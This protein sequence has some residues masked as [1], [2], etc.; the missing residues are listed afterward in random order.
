MNRKLARELCMKVIFEMLMNKT[1]DKKL[2]KN[3]LSEEDEIEEIQ[4]TYIQTVITS[5]IEHLEEINRVIEKYAI[6]WTLDRIAK[7][8]LAILQ[9]AL[10]EILYIEDIP[11]NVS[12]NE[13]VELAKKYSSNE[14]TSFINGILG[15]FIEKEGIKK[16][17]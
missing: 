17:D 9:L 8:D 15:K 2:L 16:N 5:T 10:A 7:V 6:G 13:A 14:S 1:Y 12:I 3:Y 4:A 11:Y